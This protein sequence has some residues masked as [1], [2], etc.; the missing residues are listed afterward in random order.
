M[1]GTAKLHLVRQAALA[2]LGLL[3][4]IVPLEQIHPELSP[5][6]HPALESLG[7]FTDPSRFQALQSSRFQPGTAHAMGCHHPGHPLLCTKRLGVDVP[8]RRT[9]IQGVR[10]GRFLE[11][12][13]A[14]R[15]VQSVLTLKELL[16]GCRIGL[17]CRLLLAFITLGLIAGLDSTNSP[18]QGAPKSHP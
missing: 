12:L 2:K 10:A 4:G 15:A 1:L 6:L 7:E 11:H 5:S 13:L 8:S 18:F 14:H 3:S 9:V 16:T 17:K